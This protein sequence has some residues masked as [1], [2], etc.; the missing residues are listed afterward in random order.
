MNKSTNE[1]SAN[2]ITQGAAV[3]QAVREVLKSD[4]KSG[5]KVVLNEEQRKLVT[6]ILI[7]GFNDRRIPLKAS[8]ANDAKLGDPKQLQAYIKGLINNWLA[9]S[10]EL[11][12]KPKKS[13]LAATIEK[14]VPADK[15]DLKAQAPAK[16]G[17]EGLLTSKATLPSK[18]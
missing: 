18:K 11:N 5:S 10:P 1:S 13:A 7:K 17:S 8:P 14:E 4:Y 12:G 15:Q 9:K 2:Q 6:D 3:V 16:P